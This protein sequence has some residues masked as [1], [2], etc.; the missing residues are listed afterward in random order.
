MLV[1]YMPMGAAMLTCS[2]L[3]GGNVHQSARM[4]A[5]ACT[6]LALGHMFGVTPDLSVL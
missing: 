1:V 2:V 6:A 5:L 4:M 3:R